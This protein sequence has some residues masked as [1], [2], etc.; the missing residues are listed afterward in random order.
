MEWVAA[1]KKKYELEAQREQFKRMKEQ[2][3]LEAELAATT[4]KVN[5]L[6][7]MG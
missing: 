2:L 1:Q 3:E 7:I 4:V 5:V 6:E